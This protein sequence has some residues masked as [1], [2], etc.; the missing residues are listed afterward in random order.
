MGGEKGRKKTMA[1]WEAL[2]S[3]PQYVKNLKGLVSLKGRSLINEVL[4]TKTYKLIK[5]VTKIKILESCTQVS[6]YSPVVYHFTEIT[7][8]FW[9][10]LS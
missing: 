7:T 9:N 3:T 6:S 4:Q 8:V 2:I 10:E 5:E 1:Y